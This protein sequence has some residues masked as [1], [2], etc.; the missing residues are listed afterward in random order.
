[1]DSL[2][3]IACNSQKTIHSQ[4]PAPTSNQK[5]HTTSLTSVQTLARPKPP[6]E[7]A[8]CSIYTASY[9]SRMNAAIGS[10][11][12]HVTGISWE[13]QQRLG[14]VPNKAFAT[15]ITET[16]IIPANTLVWVGKPKG[17]VWNSP[18]HRLHNGAVRIRTA[19]I[20]L[21]TLP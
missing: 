18:T 15:F 16:I 3:Q 19:C 17:R 20:A 6:K 9:N 14:Q 1:M 5:R 8:T 11:A 4:L 7:E 12:N 13:H 2:P 10:T 21:H